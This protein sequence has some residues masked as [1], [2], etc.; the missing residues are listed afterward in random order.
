MS[1]ELR[2]VVVVGLG[3][4][5]VLGFFEAGTRLVLQYSGV[6]IHLWTCA[7][8]AKPDP[9]AFVVVVPTVVVVLAVVVVL[10]VVVG[11]VVV[12]LSL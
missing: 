10:T 7:N 1:S 3:V 11:V 9:G 5:V 12:L 6:W 2:D 4:V 8:K